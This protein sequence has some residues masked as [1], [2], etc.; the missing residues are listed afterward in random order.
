MKIYDNKKPLIS[1][2]LP[3][4]G[5]TSFRTILDKWFGDEVY[6][7]YYNERESKLPEKI[8]TSEY[9]CIHG[10]F[11]SKRG[12]GVNSYYPQV[13]Q[14]VMFVRNPLDI[15]VS[16]YFYNKSKKSLIYRD[17]ELL[18]KSQEYENINDYLR[19]NN[20]YFLN[21]L[22]AEINE[23]NYKEVLNSQF[24]Y[25]GVIENY[26]QSINNLASILQKPTHYVMQI[27][28]STYDEEIDRL[29]RDDFFKRHKLEMLIYDYLV[30]QNNV[31]SNELAFNKSKILL[32]YEKEII[33]REKEIIAREKE[34]ILSETALK[35]INSELKLAK[36]QK[37][38]LE[39]SIIQ[40]VEE[41]N[42]IKISLK[43]KLATFLA[44][45]FIYIRLKIKKWTK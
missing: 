36:N 6:Y 38:I 28:R 29:V 18:S 33:A 41:L 2:H 40:K 26:Q 13:D 4:C 35:S 25:V 14:F 12:F 7:H 24:I 3:K 21:H 45:P 16:T 23:T 22:P 15:M 27:N 11:N 34:I 43:Y 39:D 9:K 44:L 32:E 30:E 42:N 20:S 1:I 8:S 37:Q 10:H 31:T 19:N 17:G 5:G